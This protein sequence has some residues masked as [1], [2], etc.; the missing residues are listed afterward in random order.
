VIDKSKENLWVRAE[1]VAPQGYHH[2][3]DANGVSTL[4]DSYDHLSTPGKLVVYGFHSMLPKSGGN[5]DIRAWIKIVWNWFWTPTFDPLKMTG[6][7]KSVLAFNLSYLFDMTELFLEKMDFIWKLV[8]EGKVKGVPHFT[9]FP[10][11]NVAQAHQSL[12]SGNTIGKMI[13]TI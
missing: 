7:N 13:L 2:I 12:E 8:D 11:R 1:E 10:F 6:E 5:L 4:K 9:E 3:Y